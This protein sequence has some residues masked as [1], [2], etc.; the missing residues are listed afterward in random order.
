MIKAKIK[1]KNYR[2]LLNK[3]LPDLMKQINEAILSKL[4]MAKS[5]Y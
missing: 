3:F 2:T 5:I 1:K 4:N